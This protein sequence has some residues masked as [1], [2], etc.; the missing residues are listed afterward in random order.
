MT[1]LVIAAHPDDEVLGCGASI[2]KW[3][4]AGE[5]VH[6]MIMAEGVT[7]RDATRNQEIR[8]KE[9]STLAEAANQAGAI[10]GSASVTLLD[11]PDNRMDSV[12]LLDV[13]KPIEEQV[14]RLMPDTVVTHHGGDLNIDHR[15]IHEAVVT[16]CRPQ[17][18][19]SVQRIL[20]FEVASSTEWQLP[21]SAPIF[22]PNWFENVSA[23]IDRKLQALEVYTSEMRPWPHA[24]STKAIEYLARWRG[25]S[26]GVEAAEAFE[27]LRVVA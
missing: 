3:A 1:T 23:T 20:V 22:Q 27:L 19:F 6:I 4:K 26:V 7:S 9:L 13:I 11:F 18:G 8:A 14:S 2:A 10:L 21:G 15:I 24:R 25:A 16:A 17:P 12:D 5:A